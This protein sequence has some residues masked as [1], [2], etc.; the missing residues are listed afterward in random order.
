MKQQRHG[1]TGADAH[2]LA[3]MP[4]QRKA[5]RNLPLE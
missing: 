1:S 4:F 5:L 3:W 2:Y